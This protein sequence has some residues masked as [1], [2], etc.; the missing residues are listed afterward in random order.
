MIKKFTFGK[1]LILSCMAMLFIS[2]SCSRSAN[3]EDMGVKPEPNK[4]VSTNSIQSPGEILSYTAKFR[5]KIIQN[6]NRGREIGFVYGTKELPTIND[7]KVFK[8]IL[9]SAEYEIDLKLFNV[10]LKPNTVYY[11]R[12]YM[13]N[14]NGTNIYTEQK[15]F[16]T[17]GYYGPAGGYVAYDKGETSDGWRYLEIYPKGLRYNGYDP[18]WGDRNSFLSGTLPEIG[19]GLENT[20]IITKKT[21]QSNCA[22]TLCSN[23]VLNGFSDWFL[24]S[25][26]EYEIIAESLK[27]GGIIDLYSGWTST[28]KDAYYAYYFDYNNKLGTSL[29][30]IS[31]A[32]YPVRRY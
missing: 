10:V 4:E 5:G 6:E 13:K 1:Q 15:Q 11:V 18:S 14:D 9:G 17:T 26:E 8:S 31:K 28:Q 21:F 30:D 12:G 3:G 20:E 27:V 25:K 7:N 22:A 2:F 32:A 19:K 23:F 16:R 24:P 29:K